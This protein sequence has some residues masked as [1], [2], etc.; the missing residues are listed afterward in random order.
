MKLFYREYGNGEPLI[1]LHGLYG[2]SDNWITIAHSLE[3]KFRVIVVDQ[4]NHGQSPHSD[5]HNY[6]LMV[7]DLVELF[8]DLNITKASII[9]H[10]MGGKVAM[11]FAAKYPDNINSLVVVDIA[12]WSYR[13]PINEKQL[14]LD[15]H[16][17][18]IASLLSIPINTITLRVEADAILSFTISSDR[19]RHFLLK[20]L[21]RDKDG[22]FSWKLN[23][24]AIKNNLLKLMEGIIIDGKVDDTKTL[25]IRGELSNYIPADRLDEIKTLF[26]NSTILTIAETGHW[27]H[28]EKPEEFKESVLKFLR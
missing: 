9:G 13:E 18:I 10:S 23:I 16:T 12:P 3:S 22:I 21:N 19:V 17:K 7:D 24:Q 11:L 5:D 4:R 27:V 25:F 15:E 1:I 26:P 28:A 8:N 2:S 6:T 14:W 20:N